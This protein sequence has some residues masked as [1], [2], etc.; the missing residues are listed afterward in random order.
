MN[1]SVV[2]ITT[3]GADLKLVRAMTLKPLPVE[4]NLWDEGKDSRSC[5]TSIV[6]FL[7]PVVSAYVSSVGSCKDRC[8]EL[9]EA[10]PP[11][12]RCDNLCKT[13]QGCCHDFDTQCLKTGRSDVSLLP[14]KYSLLHPT[15]SVSLIFMAIRTSVVIPNQNNSFSVCLLVA[16]WWACSAHVVCSYCCKCTN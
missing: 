1:K 4:M 7:C 8:F 16:G 13:Y 15:C 9:E 10:Q 5:V 3:V 6:S 11:G 2:L 12:C 14:S